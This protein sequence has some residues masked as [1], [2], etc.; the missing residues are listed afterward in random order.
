M[1][2]L[3]VSIYCPWCKRHSS[4]TPAITQVSDPYGYERK[5]EAFCVWERE[6]NEIWW[7][8]VCS[9]C[10]KPVLVLN[11]GNEIYPHPL[12][13]PS[14]ERIPEK[15]RKD[16]DEAKLC[17]S[18]KAYRASAVMA[19]RA[20]QTA[21]IDKGASKGKNLAEQIKELADKGMI[22]QDLKN[23]AD[24]V[25]FVGN[26]AA[27]PTENEVSEDDAKDIIDLAEQFMHVIYVAPAIA[28]G[29]RKKRKK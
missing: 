9:Y 24:V 2:A 16:L 22:T 6:H 10:D 8:G 19:R 28:N 15:I 13:S 17:F 4:I 7:I 20:L 1:A 21:C 12:P 3:R 5:I 23:W 26:D 25:R 11:A 29:R 27:H 18:V 14:D